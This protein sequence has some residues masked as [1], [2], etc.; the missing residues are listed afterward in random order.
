VSAA[1]K[2]EPWNEFRELPALLLPK[3]VAAILRVSIQTVYN[4]KHLGTL[5]GVVVDPSGQ[6]FLVRKA[7]LLKS[8]QQ[9]GRSP[10]PTEES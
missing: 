9:Q 2:Q 10:T 1:E 3:E 8:L 7:I 5:P 4:R 6:G